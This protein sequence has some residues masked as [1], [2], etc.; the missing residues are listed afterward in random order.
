MKLQTYDIAVTLHPII[1]KV[2]QI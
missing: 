1:T 2:L